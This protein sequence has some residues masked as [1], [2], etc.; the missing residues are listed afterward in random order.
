MTATA[1]GA[2]RMAGARY[3]VD[4][5]D[6]SWWELGWD[7]PLATFYAQHWGAGTDDDAEPVAEWHGTRPGQ[8][9]SV[10]SLEDALG[11]VVPG[12]LR[13]ELEADRAAFAPTGSAAG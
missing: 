5:D 3:E 7:P 9:R 4:L 8:H 2:D 12:Q 6:G 11:W 10:A 1:P 13:A